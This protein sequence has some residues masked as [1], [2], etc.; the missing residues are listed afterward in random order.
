MVFNPDGVVSITDKE[1]KGKESFQLFIEKCCKLTKFDSDNVLVADFQENY[2]EFCSM[3]HMQMQNP[4][5]SELQ[6]QYNI[7]SKF[8]PQKWIVREDQKIQQKVQENVGVV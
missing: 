6:K 5:S 4:S 7:E 1:K 8:L 2:Q 3:N